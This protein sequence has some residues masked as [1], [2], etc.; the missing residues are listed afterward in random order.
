M[1]KTAETSQQTS[2]APRISYG[3]H[4]YTEIFQ[5]ANF[6]RAGLQALKDNVTDVIETELAKKVTSNIIR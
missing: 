2:K 5:K 1:Q 3:R 4:T 6:Q